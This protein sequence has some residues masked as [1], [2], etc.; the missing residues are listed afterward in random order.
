MTRTPLPNRRYGITSKVQW[1]TWDGREQIFDCTF[2]FGPDAYVRE[3][4]MRA[5]K[6]GSDMD[7]LLS[8]SCIAISILLQHGETCES[9]CGHFGEN[10]PEGEASGP[11][12]SPLG[13]IVRVGADLDKR[14][15]MVSKSCSE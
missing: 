2:G 10:R 1:K 6:E 14:A 9:L 5:Q 3:V 15:K 11:A 7:A 4:F 13:A 12:S 8:D